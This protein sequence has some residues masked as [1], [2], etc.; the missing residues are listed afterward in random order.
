VIETQTDV[1]CRPCHKPT[2]RMV[3]HR[4]MRDIGTVQVL[5]AVRRALTAVP[6]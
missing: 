1:P 2:C 4:C 3:H 5:T 6:A